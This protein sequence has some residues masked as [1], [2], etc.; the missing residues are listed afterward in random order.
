MRLEDL[1][2]MDVE[3]YLK[4]DNRIILITG[5]TEQHSYLSLLTDILVP[6]RIALAVAEREKVLVAPPLNFGVSTLFATF[7]GTI[8]LSQATFD[9]VLGEIV[10][11]LLHQ[12]FSGFFILN[13]HGGNLM[14]PV[15]ED[16]QLEGHARIYWYDWYKS[17]AV[18][19]FEARYKLRLDHANWGENFPFNR[20]AESPAGEKPAVNLGYLDEGQSPREVLGDGNFGGPYQVDDALMAELYQSVVDEACVLIREIAH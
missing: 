5:A 4:T 10:Q 17:P 8:S 7:P 1:N 2:W 14:P 3:S 13:G 12:G 11:S 16:I 15:L 19:D 20:V 9:S 18:Q 6:S